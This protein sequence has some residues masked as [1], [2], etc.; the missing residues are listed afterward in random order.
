MAPRPARSSP[1]ARRPSTRTCSSSA[2]ARPSSSPGIIQ[3]RDGAGK[4]NEG[5]A[6][7][8]VPGAMKLAAGADDLHTGM[9]RLYA[10]TVQLSAGPAKL[11]DGA[12]QLA[13]GAGQARGR[14]RPARRGSQTAYEGSQQLTGGLAPDQRRTRSARGQAAA[15]PGRHQE[16]AGRCRPAP[17][18][19]R[20]LR[21][22]RTPHRWSHRAPARSRHQLAH[23]LRS[24]WSAVCS[25]SPAPSAGLR[26]ILA[27]AQGCKAALRVPRSAGGR[28]SDS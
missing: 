23:R 15:A 27:G 18:R 28:A 6:D 2:T 9:G 25:S 14:H 21:R 20:R 4:L 10:G 24:T 8:A 22:P 3:L 19:L 12:G 17:R 16:A 13:D 26:K 11:A 1:T 7:T 5:L